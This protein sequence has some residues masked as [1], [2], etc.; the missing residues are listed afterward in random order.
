MTSPETILVINVTR[1]GDTLLTTPTLRA[2]AAAWPRAELTFAGHPKRIEILRHLPYLQRVVGID[3]RVAR[4][5]GRLG[6]GR[7]DLALVYGQDAPLVEYALRVADKV[8]AF[9][10]P[11]ESINR[12]LFAIAGED[13]YQPTHAVTWLMQML[14]P[15]GV[16]PAGFRLDYHVTAAEE[17]WAKATLARHRATGRPLIGLQ[18]ASFPTKSFRDWP[19]AHFSELCRRI[20]DAWPQAH[21]LIYGG[22][23]EKARAMELYRRYP[24]HASLFAGR[25]SLRQTA[26]LMQQ[27]DLYVGV[28]TGPTHIMGALWRPMIAM[29]HPTSPRRAL[30]PLGHPCCYALD[31]PLADQPAATAKTPMADIGVDEVWNNVRAALTGQDVPVPLSTHWQ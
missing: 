29:Y 9:R 8:V 17:A 11:S 20:L 31:H 27:T 25:L 30:A 3:K 10:Q 18:L 6:S 5:L 28:D 12:R 23:E 19:P 24:L 16:A 14:R 26:A 1:I 7:F 15:L 21:F 22:N 4:L 2:L 13:A